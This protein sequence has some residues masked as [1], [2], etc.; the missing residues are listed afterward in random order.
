MTIENITL[1][2]FQELYRISKSD[3]SEED[4][5]TESVAAMAGITVRQCEDMSVLDFNKK[6]KEIINVLKTPL[7]EAKAKKEICGYGILYE[8]AKLNRGQYVTL[9]HF[10]KWDIILNCHLIMASLTY[11]LKTNLHD[12]N[13]HADIAEKMKEAKLVD[14]YPACVFFYTLFK[15]SI[16][17]LRSCLV[18]DMMKT[19]MKKKQAE[20]A[21]MN[22]K[23]ALDGFTMPKG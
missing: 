22:L 2:Q 10:L 16:M 8:P 19:G 3:L 14:I 15:T 7:P 17:S 11:N 6:A 5:I 12:G 20:A 1:G 21:M 23:A 4:K 13:S 9:Q 18:K